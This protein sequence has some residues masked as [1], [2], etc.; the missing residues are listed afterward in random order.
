MIV[1]S[2]KFKFEADKVEE[3]KA[4]LIF[5]QNTTTAEDGCVSFRFYQDL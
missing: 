5:D 4:S 1:I 2:V 3:A